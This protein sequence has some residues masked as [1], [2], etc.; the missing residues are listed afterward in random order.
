MKDTKSASK[1]SLEDPLNKEEI[2]V[3]EVPYVGLLHGNVI[4]TL[5]ARRAEEPI[6][7]KPGKMHRVVVGRLALTTEAA[8]NLLQSLQRLAV[9]LKAAM[10]APDKK[11]SN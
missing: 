1:P 9:A 6:E 2:F 8:G 3:S 11:P 10:P 7:G 5:A 4:I